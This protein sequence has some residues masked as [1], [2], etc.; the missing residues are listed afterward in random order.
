MLRTKCGMRYENDNHMHALYLDSTDAAQYEFQSDH[1]FFMDLRDKA[2]IIPNTVYFVDKLPDA[3]GAAN[4]IGTAN[5]AT[6]VSAIGT[7]TA[8][9]QVDPDITSDA[10]GNTRAAAWILQMVTQAY[11][12]QIVAPMECGLEVYDMVQCVDARLGV[13]TKGRVGRIERNYTPA[14]GK[15]EVSMTLGNVYSEPSSM[16]MGPGNSGVD[17]LPKTPPKIADEINTW[18]IPAAIQ[19]YQH[20]ITFTATDND[21]VAWTATNG[22]TFY[23]G[24]VQAIASGNTGNLADTDARYIYFDLDDASP[25]V[26]KVATVANYIAGLTIKK[27]VVCLVQKSSAA[28]ID[29]T[30]IPSYGKEPLITA[31]VI[32]MAGLLTVDLG[33]GRYIQKILNTQ[34]TDGKL[35]LSSSSSY[36]TGY[37]PVSKTTTFR[38][39]AI[40]ASGMVDGDFWIDTN[41]GDKPYTYKSGTGWVASYTKIDGGHITTG[42]I[43]CSVVTVQS[44]ASNP[45]VTVNSSGL[46][47]KNGATTL[48]TMDINGLIVKGQFA[49]FKHTDDS[50]SG[51]VYG[52]STELLV[53][54]GNSRDLSLSSAKDVRLEPSP[55]DD[56]VF[57]IDGTTVGAQD[58]VLDGASTYSNAMYPNV[59][60]QVYLGVT[61]GYAYAGIAAY[62]ANLKT[63][64][65]FTTGGYVDL[66]SSNYLVMPTRSSAPTGGAGRKYYD[67][68]KNKFRKYDTSWS[69]DA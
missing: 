1:A 15:Y 37:D 56:I 52:N 43:N 33:D 6:S 7:L 64:D 11:Q 3:L 25:N 9:I 44:A 49:I 46:T 68:T 50:I 26:L 41:D 51:Y 29:A 40:P 8:P 18:Q 14:D 5:D 12:G 2:I 65:I 59:D 69:D 67:T 47:L 58:I 20:D 45:S 66:S 38:Q 13:T 53:Q 24:T 22:I 55:G 34:I 48:I 27:G 32:H 42:T 4:Y 17:S 63:I 23:D 16:D 35:Y 54:S 21:T 39:D 57:K 28:T 30:I 31:D 10:E 60:E 62:I 19:G 61:G 36:A